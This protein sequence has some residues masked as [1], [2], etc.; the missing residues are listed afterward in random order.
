[1]ITVNIL[2][3]GKPIYTRSARRIQGEAD[4][5]CTYKVDNGAII[6]HHHSDGALELAKKLLEEIEEP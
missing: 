6:E 2:I 3:N 4:E 1:M 5:L